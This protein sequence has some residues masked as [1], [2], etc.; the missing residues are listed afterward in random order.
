MQRALQKRVSPVIWL[1]CEQIEGCISLIF[2]SWSLRGYYHFGIHCLSSN[3]WL[4]V[5][6]HIAITF[7][8][9]L[10][11]T[12]LT[13]LSFL[14]KINIEVSLKNVLTVSDF[15]ILI[16]S[17][18]IESRNYPSPKSKVVHETKFSLK[19]SYSTHV[20]LAQLDQHQTCKPVMVSVESSNFTGGNFIFWR[21]LDFNF[22]QKWQKC[23]ICVIYE[24][25]DCGAALL[26]HV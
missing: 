18:S 8:V 16:K 5:T 17:Y 3:R 15:Q 4:V 11:N 14:Y 7:E 9:F 22:V 6:S 12:N 19:I 26:P 25:L 21:H 13:F 24:N 2:T 20:C 1:S 23:Q 10:N